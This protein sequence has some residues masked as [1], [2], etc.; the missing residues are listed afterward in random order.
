MKISVKV[1]ALGESVTEATI[2]RWLKQNGDV[3]QLD[4]PICAVESDKATLDV[5]AEQAGQLHILISEGETV[6]VG[7]VVAEIDT[8]AAPAKEAR[9]TVPES[10][11]VA[12]P[13]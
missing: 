2:G 8:D 6:A 1:P 4:E 13:K 10:S 12:S 11:P 9:P 7:T 5:T 3:V